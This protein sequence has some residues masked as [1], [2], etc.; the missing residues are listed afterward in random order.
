MKSLFCRG[1]ALAALAAVVGGCATTE[2]VE[3]PKVKV[4]GPAMAAITGDPNPFANYSDG[5]ASDAK[6]PMAVEW[7]NQVADRLAK[8][9]DFESLKQYVMLPKNADD[10]L[11]QVKEAYRT[12]PM[13][14]TKI[15]CVS[16]LV[17]CPK[18]EKAPSAREIWTTALLKA[19][20]GSQDV[21]RKMFFLDQLRWCGKNAQMDRV[22]AIGRKSGSKAVNDF[23]MMVATELMKIERK[24]D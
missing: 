1:V 23:A 5:M 8:E 16:Q 14:A 3:T 20:E 21:Y 4:D 2:P 9:T 22:L 12:D 17:M 6:L 19:A 11:A 15:G 13:V 7:H 18:W 24:A 10:L